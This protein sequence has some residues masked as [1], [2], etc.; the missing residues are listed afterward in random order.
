MPDWSA[1]IG[2]EE[3]RSDS[4]DDAAHRRWLATL[5][6]DAPDGGTVAQGYHWC[7][8]LP[9]APTARLMKSHGAFLVPTLSTYAALADEGQRLGWSAAMLDKLARVQAR[10]IESVALA[11]SEG[12]SIV[13][14]TDLTISAEMY[15]LHYRWLETD[16]QYMP[17]RS[18]QNNS[19]TS[20]RI[21]GV[22]LPEDVLERVYHRNFER[23][24]L[25][26][27]A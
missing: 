11:K 5:D 14:G 6:R 25:K 21:H 27:Q 8:C 16:D 22:Y 17:S 3:R 1:W 24:V 18:G 13:F 10:G 23:L 19:V 26:R 12:V 4:I 9:D 20:W 2:R 15:R 7:L